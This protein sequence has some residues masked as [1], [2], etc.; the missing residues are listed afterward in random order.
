MCVSAAQAQESRQEVRIYFHQGYSRLDTL[1]RDNGKRLKAFSRQLSLLRG[2]STAFPISVRIAGVAS[3]EGSIAL[4]SRLSTRRAARIIEYM[5]RY[6]SLPDS[7]IEIHTPG[8]DWDGLARCVEADTLMPM[9]EEVLRI[10]R[11]VPE[12]TMRDGVVVDSR[13]A[14]LYRLQEMKVWYYM[15]RKFFP[16]LRYSELE[17]VFHRPTAEIIPP[18]DELCERHLEML[19]PAYSMPVFAGM[20]QLGFPA[21]QPEGKRPFYFAVR[22]NMLYDLL[23][24]PNIGVEFYLGKNWTLGADWMYSWWKTDR[25]H[26]YWRT[27]GGDLFVRRYFG[28]K[29]EEKPFQGHHIGLYGGIVTYD[30]ELGKRGYLGDRWSYGG[31]VE[32]GYS[33]PM[34]RRLN[35]DLTIGIGY[36]GGKYKEYLPMDGCYVWQCTKQRNYIGPTKLEASLVWLWGRGNV[37]PKKGGRL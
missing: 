18:T 29:A 24:V 33:M 36:L 28:S 31:G 34:S 8:V 16:D 12:V 27:Y 37:N 7:L 11:E 25:K 13:K 9:R 26:Y 4:N 10:L 14:R 6:I 17:I 5:R 2:D 3:P 30:F 20:P 32:Y 22:T 15:Y 23:L 1:F 19:L 35:L 21:A